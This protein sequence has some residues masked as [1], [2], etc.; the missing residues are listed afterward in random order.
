M[1]NSVLGMLSVAALALASL[2]CATQP[3]ESEFIIK[4]RSVSNPG[5]ASSDVSVIV[6]R[7]PR[8]G[9][10]RKIIEF[11]PPLSLVLNNDG[12]FAL[13]LGFLMED[14]VNRVLQK[15]ISGSDSRT[16]MVDSNVSLND[17]V[18]MDPLKVTH[19]WEIYEPETAQAE[20]PSPATTVGEPPPQSRIPAE[21][22][23]KR[24]GFVCAK[25][26]GNAKK[27][28]VES[29]EIWVATPDSPYASAFRER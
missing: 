24:P 16:I 6:R 19:V 28:S 25:L 14:I 13:E 12:T 26:S 8:S 15:R 7:D 21:A 9:E 18:T 10:S 17:I 27:N 23:K 22:P 1:R 2:S 3:T 20:N 11:H 4:A 29:M 5:V